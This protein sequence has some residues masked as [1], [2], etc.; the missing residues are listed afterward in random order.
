MTFAASALQGSA[1]SC[2]DTIHITQQTHH[3]KH[4]VELEAS[5]APVVLVGNDDVG[6]CMLS[7]VCWL[8]EQDL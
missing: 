5:G 7:V 4:L 2:I 1:S 6:P 8:P 3:A